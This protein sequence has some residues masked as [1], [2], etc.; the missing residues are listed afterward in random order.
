M[1]RNGLSLSILLVVLA[2]GAAL[3]SSPA[4]PVQ[5]QEET[6]APDSRCRNCHENL[7]LLHDSGQWC[8]FCEPER[9][10]TCCHGGNPETVDPEIAH[11]GLVANPITEN[12]AIC[13]DCHPD[14]YADRIMRFSLAA[15][16]EPTPL[17]A[18][19]GTSRAPVW[20]GP[21]GEG[22][23]SPL[24][25]SQPMAPWQVAALGLL[26]GAFLAT[27]LFG[28]LC[29]RADCLDHITHTQEKPL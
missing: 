10:C 17:E 1:N 22:P 24:L 20:A 28:Y 23:P 21:V 13:Q 16:I 3:T 15:G 27:V 26:G 25:E 11:E 29:W 2:A 4:L 19:T 14:D 6:P 18:P 5:A 12:P 7:Y 9:T 8:C